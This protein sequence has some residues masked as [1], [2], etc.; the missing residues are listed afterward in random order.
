MAER[1]D[2]LGLWQ[3]LFSLASSRPKCSSS[4]S[5]DNP[6]LF[7]LISQQEQI[8]FVTSHSAEAYSH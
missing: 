3:F 1:E 8:T 7:S 4:A 2:S 5:H 6:L